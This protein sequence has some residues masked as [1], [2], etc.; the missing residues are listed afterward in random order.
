MT[1]ADEGR[2]G[3]VEVVRVVAVDAEATTLLV[4]PLNWDCKLLTGDGEDIAEFV[5]KLDGPEAV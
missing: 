4:V 3:R 5:A 1:V 2:G